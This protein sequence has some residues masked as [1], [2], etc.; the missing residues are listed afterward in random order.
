MDSKNSNLTYLAVGFAYPILLFLLFVISGMTGETVPFSLNA[1]IDP[2][3]G[4][5]GILSMLLVF[6][7]L[8]DLYW[9]HMVFMPTALSNKKNHLLIV[10]FPEVIVIFGFVIGLLTNNPWAAMPFFL[11]SFANYAYGYRKVADFL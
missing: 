8:L 5:Y 2:Y 4:T 7:C 3:F 11:V 6:V 1:F 10:A 9:Y